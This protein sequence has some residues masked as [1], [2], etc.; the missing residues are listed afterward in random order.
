MADIQREPG[1]NKGLPYHGS[2]LDEGT[3]A[4]IER[5]LVK[6]KPVVVGGV[7][8]YQRDYSERAVDPS[9]PTTLPPGET[10]DSVV[11]IAE[12]DAATNPAATE[13]VAEDEP[14][15]SKKK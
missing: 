12:H 4:A 8:D 9:D 10:A 6:G 15:A 14:K 1:L 5:S 13:E 2:G 3:K 11:T 7:Q